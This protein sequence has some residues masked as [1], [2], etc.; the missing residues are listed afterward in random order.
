[1]TGFGIPVSCEEYGQT[2]IFLL[3]RKDPVE[4]Y[5]AGFEG[6]DELALIGTRQT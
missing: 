5:A 1:M 6:S 2:Q 3:A 4:A